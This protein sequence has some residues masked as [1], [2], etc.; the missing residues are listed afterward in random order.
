MPVMILKL[1]VNGYY[2]PVKVD[3]TNKKG[4]KIPPLKWIDLSYHT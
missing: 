1:T 3:W 4:G 2:C